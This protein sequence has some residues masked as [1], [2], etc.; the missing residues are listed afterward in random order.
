[1]QAKQPYKALF[2]ERVQE[3]A[4]RQEIGHNVTAAV[5]TLACRTCLGSAKNTPI[6]VTTVPYLYTN[7]GV[8]V[9]VCMCVCMCVC[10]SLPADNNN[11][12]V[13]TSKSM[14]VCG[15]GRLYA[16]PPDSTLHI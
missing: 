12:A 13:D 15:S 5:D 16:Q 6:H 2:L 10:V 4:R 1:M 3:L 8:C 11:N 14:R 7:Y 9:C